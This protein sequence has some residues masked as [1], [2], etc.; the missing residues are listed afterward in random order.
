MADIECL[1][2]VVVQ[3]SRT[4]GSRLTSWCSLFS[5]RLTYVEQQIKPL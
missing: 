1:K 4:E 3:T 5:A 2:K